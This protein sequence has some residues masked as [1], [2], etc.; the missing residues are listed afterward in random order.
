[1]ITRQE[2]KQLTEDE[3]SL[4]TLGSPITTLKMGS[5]NTSIATSTD[6]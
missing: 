1:M 5:P 3:I 6:T 2:Q 4:W